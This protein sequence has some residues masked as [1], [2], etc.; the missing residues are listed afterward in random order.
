MSPEAPEP[1]GRQSQKA[2]TTVVPLTQKDGHPPH[3]SRAKEEP[4]TSAPPLNATFDPKEGQPFCLC[5]PCSELLSRTTLLFLLGLGWGI[6]QCKDT[7]TVWILWRH[8]SGKALQ[9]QNF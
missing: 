6:H 7:V 1:Q 3:S 5:P 9:T 2:E 8:N 4:K